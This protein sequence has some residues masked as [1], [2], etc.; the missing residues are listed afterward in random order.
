MKGLL[1]KKSTYDPAGM[2]RCKSMLKNK[3]IYHPCLSSEGCLHDAGESPY[4][5]AYVIKRHHG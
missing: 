2:T 5:E 1:C 3:W 4:D